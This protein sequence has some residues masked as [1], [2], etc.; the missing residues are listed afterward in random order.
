[1]DTS[2]IAIEGFFVLGERSRD[3]QDKL[4]IKQTIEKVF[5]IQ[6]D[7]DQYYKE[8]FNENIRGYFEGMS[9]HLQNLPKIIPSSQLI[10]LA[11]LV[12]KCLKNRE[13]V[14][15]VGDTGCGKTTLCQIF[16][17]EITKQSLFQINCH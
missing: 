13:P 12:E 3:P 2:Q 5:N 14:L 15:L 7:L 9:A 10:R 6:I 16:A 11:V 4:Y 1:M 8:Y 17:S